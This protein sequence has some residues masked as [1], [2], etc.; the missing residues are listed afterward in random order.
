MGYQSLVSMIE[1]AGPDVAFEWHL[2]GN[3]YPPL[4]PSLRATAREVYERIKRGTYDPKELLDWR[5]AND[6]HGKC[7]ARS[8]VLVCHL[9][10][11]I[12]Y[13]EGGV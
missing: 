3:L 2:S 11:F 4:D 5:L 13:Y 6:D 8:V 12:D 9:D 1:A 7:T 10:A